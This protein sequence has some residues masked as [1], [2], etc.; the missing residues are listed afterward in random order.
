MLDNGYSN[1]AIFTTYALVNG[2]WVTF[3]SLKK[4]NSFV[5]TVIFNL[6]L[7]EQIASII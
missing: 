1:H 3:S 6:M 4:F 2:H 7:D 5:I